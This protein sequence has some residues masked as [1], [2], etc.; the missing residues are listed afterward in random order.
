MNK[1]FFYFLFFLVS[2]SCISAYNVGDSVPLSVN[3][4]YDNGL[5]L[6]NIPIPCKLSIFNQGTD[7]FVLRNVSMIPSGAYHTYSFIPVL[8]GSYT[9]SVLCSYLGDSS[10]F[11]FDFVVGAVPVVPSGGGRGID[12]SGSSVLQGVFGNA[13]GSIVPEHSTYVVNVKDDSILTY[14]TSYLVDSKPANAR[15]SSWKLLRDGNVLD[16]GSFV[17]SSLGVYSFSYDFKDLPVGD[18]QVAE[19]FDNKPILVDV[20]VVSRS[21]DLSMISGLVTLDDGSFSVVK[22]GL[23]LFILIIIIASTILL[24]RSLRKKSV[25]THHVPSNASIPRRDFNNR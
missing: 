12:P 18:Y 21:A 6:S 20:R 8:D 10:V 3:A 17:I 5:S 9:A 23:L 15:V 7:V 4:Q 11:W 14:P 24:F 22:S 25:T 1:S 13:S 2:I 16:E 19:S